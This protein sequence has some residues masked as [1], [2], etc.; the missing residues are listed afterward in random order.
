MSSG[1]RVMT[2]YAAVHYDSDGEDQPRY[3]L[4]L[5]SGS[6]RDPAAEQSARQAM[7]HGANGIWT[8]TKFIPP[9]AAESPTP[10]HMFPVRLAAGTR[11]FHRFC[12]RRRY[13]TL[14]PRSG[15]KT[16]CLFIDGACTNNGR[17]DVVPQA[18]CA[19]VFNHRKGGAVGFPLEQAGPDGQVHMHTS[20]RAELRAVIAA[21]DFRCWGGEGWRRLVVVTDS[22]YVAN[23]AT[24]L[25]RKWA[26][27]GW[28]T[29]SRKPVQNRDLWELL[30]KSLGKCAD[31]GCE[32]SFWV[33]PREWNRRA[34]RAARKAAK[35]EA[36]ERF[37][38]IMGILC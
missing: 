5:S 31:S 29:S 33:V 18:G 2:G 10:Q 21:L 32:V 38:P 11:E 3:L 30:N 23:G 7:G 26:G 4:N 34:D 12:L 36:P 8:A 13:A 17:T 24:E 19:F 25:M 14:F 22:E 16:M 28:L 35:E 6:F 1:H 37:A 15:I 9:L 27:R 20:N